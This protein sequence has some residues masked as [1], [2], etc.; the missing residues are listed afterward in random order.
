MILQRKKLKYDKA[1]EQ[2]L[3]AILSG[4]LGENLI[5]PSEPELGRMLGIGLNTVRT[6]LRKLE[7][8][9]III[10]QH[11]RQSRIDP[12]ALRKQSGPLRRIAWVDSARIG[13]TNPIYF[14][15]FRTLSEAAALRNVK[16]D[17]I[18]LAMADLV[19]SF[20]DRQ[21]EYDGL[22]LAEFTPAYRHYLDRITHPNCVSV[23][24]I[25][26]GI[27]HC[28][29]TDCYL[30]GQLA[31]R[32]LLDSGCS[33][34]ACILYAESAS[35]Y[36]PYK[37]RLRGFSDILAEAGIELPPERIFEI[38]TCA[39]EDNFPCFL[40]RHLAVLKKTDSIFAF[41]DEQAVETIHALRKMGFDIPEQISIIG[42]DG[43]ILSQFLSPPLTTIRQPV[44]EIGRKAL[45]IV[46]NPAESKNYPEVIQIPPVLLPGES[47]LER[48]GKD[49]HL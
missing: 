5:L 46:L 7:T 22:V 43:L 11:G 29:K 49:K 14:D 47:I 36:P 15:I 38:R 24:C 10:K 2:I 8:E 12:K 39:D 25:Y 19:E 16:V 13:H 1:A 42:F 23:D 35:F 30:G 9:R 33:R 34:P 45:E 40:K 21:R 4:S 31:A 41:C 48:K 17:Y 6:A 20:F 3:D 37:E 32:A 18:S 26:P 27:A 28:V 44:E